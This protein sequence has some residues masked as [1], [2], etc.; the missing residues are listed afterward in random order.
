MRRI[1]LG[2][3]ALVLAMGCAPEE[4]PPASG[5]TRE[6]LRSRV[7]QDR[8]Q[9]AVI[10]KGLV[11]QFWL[12]VRAGAEDAG[13]DFGAAVRWRGPEAETD[14]AKQINIVDDMISS[15]VDAIVL[16][17]TDKE[18]LIEP[19]KR[20]VDAGITVVTIDSGVDSDL[21]ISFV[22]TDNVKGAQMAADELAKLIGG[23]GEVG[24]IPF[25]PGA[26]TSEMREQGFKEGLAKYPEIKLVATQYSMS[27]VSKGM[28]VAQDMMTAN[29][30]LAGIFAANESG[31]MG[32]AQA[33]ES[34]N[35]AGQIKLVAF[36]AAE[37]EIDALERGTIQAL[38]VQN[39]Y[40][41]GYQGVKAA[42]DHLKGQ[43]VPK[44]IDTGVTVVTKEN[45]ESPEVQKLLNPVAPPAEEA[46][47]EPAP[48]PAAEGAA[49][50]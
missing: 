49:Q 5:E 47:A 35:R 29:P 31:A 44:R 22:A 9:V 45:L 42:I 30:N 2:L 6:D 27:D 3:A 32:A 19:V 20:A 11:H 48:A 15:G 40:Q 12:T 34:G 8:Y 1:W 25:V 23:K 46:P 24:L 10:P 43:D 18:A 37:E 50:P 17:A 14:V 21:P 41:M 39:P 33:I 13:K 38:V 4:A 7:Q 26:A 28:S 36:D 16:A